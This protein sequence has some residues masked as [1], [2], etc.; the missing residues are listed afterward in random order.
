MRY[1]VEILGQLA[2]QEA[3]VLL[4]ASLGPVDFL[5]NFSDL[6]LAELPDAVIF[7]LLLLDLADGPVSAAVVSDPE[8]F[9]LRLSFGWE[10]SREVDGLQ[11]LEG[12]GFQCFGS[13]RSCGLLN[14]GDLCRCWLFLLYFCRDGGD[15]LSLMALFLLVFQYLIGVL[16]VVALIH[17]VVELAIELVQLSGELLDLG[18]L[19]LPVMVPAVVVGLQL[20]DLSLGVV[21]SGAHFRERVG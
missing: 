21:G 12:D 5:L 16:Q 14:F 15:V 7:L 1:G 20:F 8:L 9:A 11:F 4:E 19:G 2:G 17:E 10:I 3:S 18:V 13:F 6:L